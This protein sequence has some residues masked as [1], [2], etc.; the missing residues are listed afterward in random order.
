[1][2]RDPE[3]AKVVAASTARLVLVHSRGSPADMQTLTEYPKL[4]VDVARE[5]T[6]S[7]R[8]ALDAGVSPER[9]IVDPGIG[10]AKTK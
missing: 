1:L 7:V 6:S 8:R 9:I 3:L 2:R 10:F 4:V 5:L